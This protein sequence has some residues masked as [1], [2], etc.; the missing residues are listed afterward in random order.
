MPKIKDVNI[1]KNILFMAIYSLIDL[2]TVSIL[3]VN[4]YCFL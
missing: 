4:N 2:F 3:K 1:I